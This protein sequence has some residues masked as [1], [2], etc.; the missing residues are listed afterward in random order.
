MAGALQVGT[1]NAIEVRKTL[2]RRQRLL[3]AK[4]G[5]GWISVALPATVLVPFGLPVPDHQ[6]GEPPAGFSRRHDDGPAGVQGARVGGCDGTALLCHRAEVTPREAF[7]R[8]PAEKAVTSSPTSANAA[9]FSRRLF[10]G[11]TRTPREQT[12]IRPLDGHEAGFLDHAA[13]E[14]SARDNLHPAFREIRP[15]FEVT[16]RVSQ[17]RTVSLR[18]WQKEAFDQL[19]SS[20]GRDFFVVAT[21]GA[22][23]TT[24]ALTAVVH[25]LAK[26]PTDPVVVVSPTQHLKAQWAVAASRFGLSMD[27]AWR[28]GPIAPDVHG[29]ISTYQQ[30]ASNPEAL[31]TNARNAVVVLDEIHHAGDE[32]SWGGAVLQ[33]FQHARFRLSLSGTPFRSDRCEIPFLQYQDFEAQPDFEYG[34]GEA[35]H[36]GGVVRPVVFP[37]VGGAMEWLDAT[38]TLQNATFADS[39]DKTTASQRLRTALAADGDWLR[40]VLKAADEQ[41]TTSRVRFPNAGGLVIAMDQSHARSIAG[42]LERIRGRKVRVA[43]SDD[44]RATSH[45]ARFAE[46]DEPWLVAVRMVSEGVDIPRLRVG[47]YA[48]TTTTELFFRQAVGR[49]VR[50]MPGDADDP[51]VLFLPD[52]ARLARWANTLTEARRH[53]VAPTQEADPQDIADEMSDSQ[54]DAIRPEPQMSLFEAISATPD[55]GS[56]AVEIFAAA[57]APSAPVQHVLDL[58]LVPPRSGASLSVDGGTSD[59]PHFEVRQ[60]LRASNAERARALVHT[61]GRSHAEVNRELNRR[62]GITSIDTATLEQLRRRQRAAESWMQELTVKRSPRVGFQTDS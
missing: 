33:A 8:P 47:V 42:V 60:Q 44:P 31:R 35:L 27:P 22:G 32:R 2:N 58:P 25:H 38:G 15:R 21:P 28:P 9:F 4:Q 29:I 61:T 40:T 51:A 55:E 56:E 18:P 53:Y 26:N 5:Q 14:G 52:D 37:R 41:L 62:S 16:P 23:K 7:V 59:I 10:R 43:T 57:A 46:S 45:I 13:D 36:D 6:V 1:D 49:F 12:N 11:P 39:V 50:W 34:Y 3:F 48:T 30:V 17:S 54:L 20:D 24:L 19:A